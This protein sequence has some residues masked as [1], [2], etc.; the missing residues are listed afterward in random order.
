MQLS[1]CMITK[2]EKQNLERCLRQLVPYPFELVVADTGS[3]DGTIAM[4]R[5]YTESVYE[6]TWCDD[7]AKAKNFAVSKAKYDQVLVIDSD[8]YL[9]KIDLET[10]AAQIHAFPKAVG[11]I[12][13]INQILQGGEVR[14][15]SEYLN[16]LFNRRYYHYERKIHEQLVSIDGH[17]LETYIA[18]ITVEHSGYLLS[19]E[20]RRKKAERNIRLLERE[21]AENENDTYILYQLGKSYS[22]AGE[23]EHACMYF[24]RALSFDLDPELEYVIDMVDCYGYALLNSGQAEQA[25][26][27][28]G[29]YHAFGK[30]A[31]FQFLMGLIYMN[32]EKYEPAIREFMKAAQQ[33]ECMV[34]GVNGYLAYYNAGVIYECL[35]EREKARTLYEK[36]GG[37]SRAKERLAALGKR[38]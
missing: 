31:D 32:N 38:L 21:L 1:V 37:Y 15:S 11:R 34:K 5:Q 30:R 10:I 28:E 20:E 19:E 22:M 12:Q 18:P 23:Y 14:E 35:G 36:C 8:E 24:S 2:N 7:F 6:F 25:L 4:A 3:T 16:R 26:G 13:R 9:Q 27:F 33:K 29:I 17:S